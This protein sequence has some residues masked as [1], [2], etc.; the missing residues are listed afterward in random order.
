MRRCI[1][2]QR[3]TLDLGAPVNVAKLAT[4]PSLPNVSPPTPPRKPASP[5]G[6]CSVMSPVTYRSILVN[7][8][9]MRRQVLFQRSIG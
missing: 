7:Q 1:R 3:T 8:T 4:I 5:S 2:R 6:R 9:W